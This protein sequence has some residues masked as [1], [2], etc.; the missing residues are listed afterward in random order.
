VLEDFLRWI[1]TDIHA[2]PVDPAK[3]NKAAVSMTKQELSIGSVARDR[4]GREGIVCSGE[5]PPPKDWIDEQVGAEKIKAHEAASLRG[6]GVMPFSGGYLLCPEPELECLRMATYEDSLVA[7]ETAGVPG[8][9]R[10]AKTFPH[11]ADRAV[12]ERDSGTRS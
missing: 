5:E 10:L 2:T 6:W 12:A 11:Y 4:F 9:E 1:E 3:L 7:V 8:R